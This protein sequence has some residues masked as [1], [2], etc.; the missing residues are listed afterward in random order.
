MW[1]RAL[2]CF[3]QQLHLRQ[4]VN[5]PKNVNFIKPSFRHYCEE[6]IY[7]EKSLNQAML[8]G[9]VGI[10]PQLRGTDTNPVVVFTLATNTNYK[11]ETGEI[12]QKTQ[13]HRIS[14]FKPYL[15][16]TVYQYL[17]KGVRVYVQGR[18]MYGEI[19]DQRGNQHVTTTI[20]A[21]D[22]IF[23]G[24]TNKTVESEVE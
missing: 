13:W 4:N 17:K 3:R 14:V 2:T 22:V 21:D 16:N 5:C 18:I 15:R 19:I 6:R 24:S 1:K 12:Q 20:V 8:L 23:L 9:R 7:T 10:D 11:F